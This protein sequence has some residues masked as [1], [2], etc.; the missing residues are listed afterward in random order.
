MK[1]IKSEKDKLIRSST[2]LWY[3][4]LNWKY[5]AR[6]RIL[7]EFKKA[8]NLAKKEG[9]PFRVFSENFSE[10]LNE[11]TIQL[12][13]GYNPIGVM[14]TELSITD[15]GQS[16]K[17]SNITEKGCTLVASQGANG[18]IAFIMYP[19]ESQS[20]KKNEENIILYHHLHPDEIT[21][22][23]IRKVLQDFFLYAR[24]SSIYGMGV[25]PSLFENIRIFYLITRDIRNQK[26]IIK[27]IATFISEWGKAI[28]AAVAAYLVASYTGKP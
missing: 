20:L 1:F 4:R 5:C 18:S 17:I 12:T 19:Y 10:G 15:H 3:R 23:L 7:N 16:R 26:N 28:I 2:L 6:D 24:T 14:H 27:P 22:R 13:F 8:E 9:Y 25:K 11:E 21:E